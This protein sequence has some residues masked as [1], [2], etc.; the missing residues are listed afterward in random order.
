M[1]QKL[2]IGLVGAG[3]IVNIKHAHVFRDHQDL[4][5][6]VAIAD[7]DAKTAQERADE[8]PGTQKVYNSHEELCADDDVEVVLVA[9]PPYLAVPMATACLEAGKHVMSEKP[10]GNTGDDA[11]QLYEASLK[12]K[13]RLM[14]A[15][16]FFFQAGYVKLREMARSGDWPYGEPLMVHLHQFWKMTPKRIPQWWDSPWR[17]DERFK[18]LTWGYLIEGGCHTAN[19]VREAFG[20][21]RGIQSRMFQA[22]PKVG[23][24]DNLIA[25]CHFDNGTVGQITMSYGMNTGPSPMLQVMATHGTLVVDGGSIKLLTENGSEEIECPAPYDAQSACHAEWLHFHDVLVNGAALEFTPWQA[26][27]DILFCQNIIDA[28]RIEPGPDGAVRD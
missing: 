20:M 9:V 19:P 28:A 27:N 17:H 12:S 13:G 7:P 11:R 14:I 10:M 16:N 22:D 18:R 5:E 3:K 1:I 23:Q 4:F 21:P 25:N 6:V 15:E 2:K 26:Y 8:L 24:F